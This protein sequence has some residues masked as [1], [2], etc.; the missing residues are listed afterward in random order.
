MTTTLSYAATP[1]PG[2]AWVD[3]GH[4]AA[5]AATVVALDAASGFPK[6]TQPGVDNDSVMRLVEVR[7][8]LGGQRWF[9][10]L[11]YRMGPD[12]G[13]LMHWS[14][15]VDAPIAMLVKLFGETAAVTIW[16]V[17][18]LF[19]ALL[20][21]VGIARHAGG[22]AARLP[23]A[24]IGLTAFHF[25][26]IFASGALDHHN[27]QVVLMLVLVAGLVANSIRAGLAAGAAAAL[28]LA[29]GMETLP[30]VATAGAAVA[31]R[32]ALVGAV[33]TPR[34][35]GFGLGFAGAGAAA[36]VATIA[37]GDWTEVACDAYS[38]RQAGLAIIAGLGLAA[39]ATWSTQSPRMRIA[40]I[41]LLG[42]ICVAYAVAAMPQCLGD[43]YGGMDA[44]LRDFWLDWI[45]EA[46]PVWVLWRT[47]P[48]EAGLHYV[49]PLIALA[50]LAVGIGKRRS[51]PATWIVAAMLPVAIAVSCWQLRGAMFAL[52][53]AA[54]PLSVWVAQ[55]RERASA[56]GLA[57]GLAM[58]AAW[59]ASIN[60]AWGLAVQ[61]AISLGPG[62]QLA[63]PAL[64]Q[65]ACHAEAEFADLAALPATTV[66]AI[67]NLGPAILAYTPHR[68][69]AGPYHRNVEGNLA[70]IDTFT[71]DAAD[72]R[73]IMARYGARLLAY[74]PGND[75]SRVI[76]ERAPRGLLADLRGGRIPEWLARA[77][78]PSAPLQLFTLRE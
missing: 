27:L 18:L 50:A 51:G 30:L 5:A 16:P 24:I 49:T 37:P 6:L 78:D 31:L 64:A 43:P 9:D 4:A 53:L 66:V 2:A 74:C 40:G 11:Q 17:S 26:G 54:V 19:A 59:I 15:L 47:H 45:I 13:F 55:L 69:L 63:G 33:E 32:L 36:L 41:A 35:I 65:S 72:A 44:R 7:D 67:S 25:M 48:A 42:A 10:L 12:G 3:A 20:L 71:A 22:D 77:G 52:A 68:T 1:R 46:Q 58:A 56:G 29:V 75:E 61:G 8:L 38:G 73:Q 23:A 28:S 34:A 70:A 57:P 60:V 39:A 14:R 21:L 76:A 62:Q